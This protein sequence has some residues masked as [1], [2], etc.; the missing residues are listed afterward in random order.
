MAYNELLVN[1]IREALVHLPDVQEKPSPKT[2]GNVSLLTPFDIIWLVAGWCFF[3]RNC[4]A[5]GIY[6]RRWGVFER[7]SAL[8][9]K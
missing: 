6:I 4:A 9:L 3:S 8:D 1:K 7:I 5:T 2:R